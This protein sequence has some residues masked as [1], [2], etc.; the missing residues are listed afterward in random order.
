MILWNQKEIKNAKLVVFLQYKVANK[1][2]TSRPAILR[3]ARMEKKDRDT[4]TKLIE[5]YGKAR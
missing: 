4:I 5:K 2:T 1:D 3:P